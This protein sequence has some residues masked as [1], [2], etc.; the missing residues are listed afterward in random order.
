[1]MITRKAWLVFKDGE[2]R[3]SWM[4]KKGFSHVFLIINDGFNWIVLSPDTG[5]LT[6]KILPYP[7]DKDVIYILSGIKSMTILEVETEYD[8]G[9]EKVFA[10]F[11]PG[12]TCVSIAKYYLGLRWLT[13]TPYRLYKKLLKRNMAK[14]RRRTNGRTT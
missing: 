6:I 4:F 7:I 14:L 10:R 1:M 9:R 11:M 3:I 2:F 13:I 8:D 12:F 5:I